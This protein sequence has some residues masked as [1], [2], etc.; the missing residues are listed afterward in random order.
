MHQINSRISKGG[1]AVILGGF[2]IYTLS[3]LYAFQN[4]DVISV[5][6]NEPGRKLLSGSNYYVEANTPCSVDLIITKDTI[7]KI[8]ISSKN[9]TPVIISINT[10]LNTP[11]VRITT[12]RNDTDSITTLIARIPNSRIHHSISFDIKEGPITSD[13]LFFTQCLTLDYPGLEKVYQAVKKKDYALAR[14]YYIE[15]LKTRKTPSWFFNWQD[16]NSTNAR[17]EK[18]DTKVADKIVNNILPSCNID[19]NFGNIINWSINPT[20]P[21]Y[22]EWTWQLSRHPYWMDLGKA[23]WAT[24]N[25]K[26]AETFVRQARSWIVD[27]PRP[28]I[29][30]NEEYSRWRSLETG[31]R[32]RDAWIESFYRF[33]PSPSFDDKTIL[34]YVKTIHEHGEHLMMNHCEAG[35][36]R[37]A[38]EMNGLYKVAV[39]FPEFKKASQWEQ[40]ATQSLYEEIERQF[41]PDGAQKELA[42][43]YHGVALRSIIS[44]CKLAKANNK[45]LPHGFIEKSEKAYDYY[46]KIRM[47]NGSLPGVNDSDFSYDSDSQLKQGLEYFPNREDFSFITS[48]G[49]KGT[50]PSFKS[51][52]MP[53]AG[54]YIM[55]SDWDEEAMYSFFDVGPLGTG[56]YH[57]D[58]L[59]L[60]L[61]A[62]GNSLLTEGGNYPYDTTEWRKYFISA[63]AH[64]VTRVDGKDQNRRSQKSK[65]G[66][67][68]S[69][70]PLENRW[71]SNEYYDFGE[72]LFFE[73]YGKEQDTSTTHYRALLFIKNKFWLL[74]DVFSSNGVEEHTYETFFHLDAPDAI[75]DTTSKVVTAI[76]PGCSVLQ[77]VP[78]QN[79]YIS[80]EMIKGQQA[81]EIQGWVHDYSNGINTYKCRKVP[82]PIYKIHGSGLIVE[83]YLLL[84]LRANE[85]S[86]VN[87]V[88]CNDGIYTVVFNNGSSLMVT[89]TI[90]DGT[91]N[92]LS[93]KLFENGYE[94]S[95]EVF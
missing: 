63:S 1:V 40:Y 58:K 95:F 17:D 18:Y 15:Y 12:V 66:L 36:N 38:M 56:H 25:E 83:P 45:I 13:E 93:Y 49:K 68:Y 84:P 4:K 48:K 91:I 90:K 52:W 32:M 69:L 73:G 24:G 30:F 3:C 77:I 34:M 6:F 27:N 16:F 46:L 7:R 67:L 79:N 10:K 71:I 87:S 9:V 47:P 5:S 65:D 61:Y 22:K 64:N 14:T 81:P 62:Y 44:I 94:Q 54:W 20:S 57:E 80:V 51:V 29:L 42:P 88:T 8:T 50:K 60:L 33:L 89:P 28:D 59:S 74:F 19:Y 23:Y 21:Y 2:L 72:G 86:V 78:L 75:I 82:T 55:R 43:G 11:D 26:Y 76:N 39:M 85:E 35:S 53:W 70:K 31:I 37:F 41:Y 92:A